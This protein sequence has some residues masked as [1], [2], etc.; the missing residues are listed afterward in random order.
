MRINPIPDGGR[1]RMR[2]ASVFNKS[3]PTIIVSNDAN[4]FQLTANQFIEGSTR[5]RNNW[6]SMASRKSTAKAKPAGH[7]P[8]LFPWASSRTA[9]WTHDIEKMPPGRHHV[10]ATSDC[11]AWCGTGS[12]SAQSRRCWTRCMPI[13]GQSCASARCRLNK[14][15]SKKG[16]E[17]DKAKKR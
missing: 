9:S 16:F 2:I 13:Q 1:I 10:P 4:K 6:I 5:D 8:L 17:V 11:N 15:I 7:C 12:T 3:L 14:W